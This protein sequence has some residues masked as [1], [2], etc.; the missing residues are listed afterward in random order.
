M[1]GKIGI[2]GY[3]QGLA[4]F[5]KG[6]QIGWFSPDRF[7]V[8]AEDV[9][10]GES[11]EKPQFSFGKA[12]IILGCLTLLLR[13]TQLQ[14]SQGLEHRFLAEGNRIRRQITTAPRGSIVDHKGV[15]L[16]TN[17]PGY[18]LEIIPSELPRT[19][20]ERNA[21]IDQVAEVTQIDKDEL[22]RI[23]QTV[24][25]TSFDTVPI[26]LNLD[27]EKAIFYKLKLSQIAG[28]RV[29]FTPS[30]RYDPT[31]GLAHILGYTSQMTETD[32][33]KHPD[34]YRISPIGRSG[35]ESSYD[36]Q[37]RG[38]VGIN[39]MEVNANGQF[40]RYINNLPTQEG[41]TLY[42]S[43]DHT[44]QQEM[45]SSLKE[46]MEK[47]GAKQAV[48]IAI[49]PQTGG[50][51]ASVSLPSYDNN[52]FTHGMSAEDYNRLSEDP[53]KPLINRAVEGVYPA[54]STIKP[55]IASAALQEGTIK[56]NT[57]LDTSVGVIEIGQWKFPD[58]KVH[59]KSNVIQAIAESNDIFFYALGGG[60]DIIP[61]LGV[62]RIKK[63]LDL[64]G[65]GR[66][67]G[68]DY[69]TEQAG[70]LPDSDWKKRVKKE[71]WYIGDTYHIAIGQGNL[72]VTPLQMARAVSAIANGGRLISPHIVA[73]TEDLTTGKKEQVS[74]PEEHINLKPDVWETVRQG[75]VETVNSDSGSAR[76]LK[77][78]PFTSAGKT[79]TAQFGQEQKTHAWYIGYAPIEK[80]QIACVIL[81]EGGGE[82]NAI[83][84]PVA[85]RI[86]N[87]YL[88]DHD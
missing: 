48:G 5:V 80:P 38:K 12:L 73:E 82:G 37:L 87:T 64:F 14:I 76:S 84:V 60:W 74:Y 55:F 4:H 85:G 68:V 16:V 56:S 36:S 40:Q 26:T 45:V 9:L 88:T 39:E 11:E 42:L 57:I 53:N 2:F 21:I 86:F 43:L 65:F 17:Q 32:L 79:G 61:G 18:S 20:S 46:A 81:V 54:G 10:V 34:Y 47:N 24:A 70:L 75:M 27:R 49:D 22:R 15:A 78:L 25:L 1:R 13:L 28:I 29:S 44:L 63:Y 23:F 7:L 50:I 41:N 71:S 59:G 58:W 31:E 62:D 33:E 19:L 30:R 66:E 8:H 72:L 51:L 77:S 83:S 6:E 69:A 35:L 67:T 3:R 52:A